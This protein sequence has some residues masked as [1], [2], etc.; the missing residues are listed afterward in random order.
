MKKVAIGCD[1]NAKDLK[2]II[3]KHLKELGHECEG[4]VR[5]YRVLAPVVFAFVPELFQM[6]LDY[7]FQILGVRVASDSHLFHGGSPP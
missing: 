3:K 1:P 7:F 4:D 5:V 6:F 2:E